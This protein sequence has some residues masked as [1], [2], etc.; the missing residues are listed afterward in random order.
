AQA[1]KAD[2]NTTH[3]SQPGVAIY[4]KNHLKQTAGHNA[5]PL[6]CALFEYWTGGFTMKCM[7]N[8]KIYIFL[9]SFMHFMVFMV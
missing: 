3:V 6:F 8:M 4:E 2:R 1:H 5:L 7:K 9:F